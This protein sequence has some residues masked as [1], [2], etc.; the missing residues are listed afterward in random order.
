MRASSYFSSSLGEI[1]L[2]KSDFVASA[3]NAA[4]NSRKNGWMIKQGQKN[5]SDFKRRFFILD[6]N[7]LFYYASEDCSSFIGMIWV[8]DCKIESLEI[9]KSTGSY[10]FKVTTVGDRQYYL[11]CTTSEERSSWIDI[12]R[13]SQF[14]SVN[15]NLQLLGDESSE[16]ASARDAAQKEVDSLQSQARDEAN[17]RDAAHTELERVRAELRAHADATSSELAELRR[18]KEMHESLSSL[19]IAQ[20]EQEKV[21]MEDSLN[22]AKFE[23]DI[24]RRS[25]GIRVR[26]SGGETDLGG[27][28]NALRMWVGSWNLGASEPFDSNSGSATRLLRDSFIVGDPCDIYFLGLQE[29]VTESVFNITESLAGILA[30]CERVPLSDIPTGAGSGGGQEEGKTSSRDK[31][32]GRGDGSLMGTK[33]TGL[34]LYVNKARCN[35][36]RVI[37][38]VAHPLEKV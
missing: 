7:C 31:I 2:E 24:L 34:A 22:S 11:K 37:G 27:D 20:L 14:S 5:K 30:S 17:L 29:G 8:E 26:Q 13:E 32:H 33:F 35:D 38:C 18:D 19:A 36:V 28:A 15:N 3:L 4:K 25:K 1:K 9:E 21:S 23:C 16:L 12:L 6:R 10:P